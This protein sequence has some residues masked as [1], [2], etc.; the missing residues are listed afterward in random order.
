MFKNQVDK[1]QGLQNAKYVYKYEDS[2]FNVHQIDATTKYLTT[3][4]P[5][6]VHFALS[7]VVFIS[8]Y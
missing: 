3:F 8:K 4:K 6:F 7:N 2:I 1:F 5:G